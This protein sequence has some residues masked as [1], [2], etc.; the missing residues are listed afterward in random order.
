MW[1]LPISPLV[2]I[3]KQARNQTFKREGV[4]D[5]SEKLDVKGVEG[6]GYEV[7]YACHPTMGPGEPRKLPQQGPGQSLGR[8]K[9][10]FAALQAPLRCF[11]IFII[12]AS[13]EKCQKIGPSNCMG[14]S[15]EPPLITG[16]LQR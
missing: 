4:R 6:V 7:G 11:V 9:M 12:P 15:Y 5:G 16:L 14:S 3:I 10:D 8:K 1:L 13:I 2:N